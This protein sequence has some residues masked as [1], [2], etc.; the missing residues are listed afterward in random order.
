[1]IFRTFHGCNLLYMKNLQE[2][3]NARPS[4]VVGVSRLEDL[5]SILST[6]GPLSLQSIMDRGF[7]LSASRKGLDALY[8]IGVLSTKT[9][10]SGAIATPMYGIKE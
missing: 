2:A 7:S 8:R 5:Y 4:A 10:R 1:M 9:V 6:D 3:I